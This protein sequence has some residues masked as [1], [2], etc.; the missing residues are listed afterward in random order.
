L[1]LS[2]KGKF[3]GFN[4]TFSN[5]GEGFYKNELMES[6]LAR[7]KAE[8]D[9][10]LLANRIQLLQLE[11][12]KAMKKVEETRKKAQEITSTRTRNTF[13]Q[14]QKAEYQKEREEEDKKKFM[15][16]KTNKEQTKMAIDQKR[17]QHHKNVKSDVDAMRQTH[18]NYF[19]QVV[20]NRNEDQ[21]KNSHVVQKIKLSEIESQKKRQQIFDET[22]EKAR[23]EYES[24]IKE[25]QLQKSKTDQMIAQLEQKEF[26]LIQKLK[27]TQDLQ[28]DA[29][30]TLEK[31]FTSPINV[32]QH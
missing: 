1:S 14:K 26:A 5:S 2:P 10:Q 27:N 30:T 11:Q 28:R 15:Q 6:K 24:R 13:Q 23:K 29:S 19:G 9:A 7:K 25:E 3:N 17:S 18:K 4:S 31:A 12:D 21:M 16:N 8:E 32:Q 20:T 22:K